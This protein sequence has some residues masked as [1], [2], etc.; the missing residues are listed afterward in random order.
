MRSGN[1]RDVNE[2]REFLKNRGYDLNNLYQELE[3]SSRLVDTHQDIRQS[4]GVVRL[5][6][7]GFRD[8][9]TFYRA[10]KQE[11]GISPRQYKNLGEKA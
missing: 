8:Y 1:Y 6:S 5:H 3:M 9:S 10:F 4:G 11:Y 7:H 2:V